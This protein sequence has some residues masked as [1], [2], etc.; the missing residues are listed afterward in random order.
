MST[1]SVYMIRM[2]SG[3]L[4]TGITTDVDRRFE[5]HQNSPKGARALKG[6]GPLALVFQKE[7]GDRSLAS[8]VE[9]ALK[10]LSKIQKEDMILGDETILNTLLE[11]LTP[12]T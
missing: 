11:K 4:Y 3:N 6:K 5:E 8:K 9:Y 10:H 2:N 12:T 7:I 1:Y